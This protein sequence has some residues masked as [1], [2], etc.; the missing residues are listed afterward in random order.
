[1]RVDSLI[2]ALNMYD[3]KKGAQRTLFGAASPISTLKTIVKN[4]D[5]DPN[6]N[7]S[8]AEVEMIQNTFYRIEGSNDKF[9]HQ[10]THQVF[11]QLV[12]QL[13][14]E[15]LTNKLSDLNKKAEAINATK[16]PQKNP[17]LSS[18]LNIKEQGVYYFSPDSFQDIVKHWVEPDQLYDVGT[19][20]Y[21]RLK[22]LFDQFRGILDIKLKIDSLKEKGILVGEDKDLKKLQDQLLESFDLLLT[23][24]TTATV[25]LSIFVEGTEIPKP[26]VLNEAHEKHYK[27]QQSKSL[28]SERFVSSI[29]VACN[30]LEEVK[31]NIPPESQL[32]YAE[33]KA[34][35]LAVRQ[36]PKV[37]PNSLQND[38]AEPK[39][40]SRN[41]LN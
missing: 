25:D 20:S 29:N 4:H 27:E 15:K 31:A 1:M 14:I 17:T 26:T 41:K 8:D 5:K 12:K 13:E 33:F 30:Y 11:R 23:Y 6:E 3:K 16:R 7:L 18:D 39:K 34:N 36:N 21:D 40:S 9:K 35:L 32:K 10:V 22:A 28:F 2:Q 24:L 19:T 37:N 38:M